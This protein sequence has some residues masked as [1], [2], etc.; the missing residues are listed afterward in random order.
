MEMKYVMFRVGTDDRKVPVL[1]PQELVH[2]C[3]AEA[4]HTMDG[5]LGAVPIS[6]GS[7]RMDGLRVFCC[8]GRSESLKLESHPDDA[9]IIRTVNYTH[10][11]CFPRKGDTK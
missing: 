4:V 3:I 1:F 11:L 5:M 6:A 8:F 9:A 10:G 2:A 7:V